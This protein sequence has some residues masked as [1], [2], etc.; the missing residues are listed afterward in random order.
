VGRRVLIR[1]TAASARFAERVAERLLLGGVAE[2]RIVPRRVAA[3]SAAGLGGTPAVE[4]VVERTVPP[5]E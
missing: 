5:R 2:E 1:H 3:V 4:V